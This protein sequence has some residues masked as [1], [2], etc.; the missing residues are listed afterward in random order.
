M[1]QMQLFT[2]VKLLCMEL[3][4]F[5]IHLEQHGFE[6]GVK[7]WIAVHVVD[8][9]ALGQFTNQMLILMMSCAKAA[10]GPLINF[11]LCVNAT[12]KIALT[13]AVQES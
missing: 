10:A 6:M 8:H 2:T 12:K 3:M 7:L 5:Y 4:K 1:R 11:M 13:N 9:Y